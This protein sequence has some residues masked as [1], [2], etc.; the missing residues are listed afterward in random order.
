MLGEIGLWVGL[1]TW[2]HFEFA[3][4]AFCSLRRE[5]SALSFSAPA[6]MAAAC[7]PTVIEVNSLET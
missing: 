1:E 7:M 2:D 5:P 6:A 3:I 4:Y